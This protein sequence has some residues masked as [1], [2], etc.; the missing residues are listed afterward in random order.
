[1]IPTLVIHTYL[2]TAISRVFYVFCTNL[3][4]EA[5]LRADILYCNL[6]ILTLRTE[7]YL[8]PIKVLLA[9][10]TGAHLRL[11]LL[12]FIHFIQTAATISFVKEFYYP[13]L[14]VPYVS[15]FRIILQPMYSV[16]STDTL[17][18]NK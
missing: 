5:N 1:M 6:E 17:C 18:F 4:D 16:R 3:D 2:F 14:V 13:I 7:H 15:Q 10:P 9:M 8:F 11:R 12:L